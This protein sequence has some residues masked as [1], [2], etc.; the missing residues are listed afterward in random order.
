MSNQDT[1]LTMIDEDDE[2]RL[3]DLPDECLKSIIS[4]CDTNSICALDCTTR[5]LERLTDEIFAAKALHR[6][7]LKTTK[8]ESG[9]TKWRQGLALVQ[10]KKMFNIALTQ[11]PEYVCEVNREELAYTHI[12]THPTSS[13]ILYLG[14]NFSGGHFEILAGGNPVYCRDAQTLA[15]NAPKAQP[16][17]VWHVAACGPPGCE[18]MV[19]THQTEMIAYLGKRQQEIRLADFCSDVQVDFQRP[20]GVGIQLLGDEYFLIAVYHNA[21]FV[22][23][24]TPMHDKLLSFVSCTTFDRDDSIYSYNL[25]RACPEV[26][27]VFGFVPSVRK[28]SVWQVEPANSDAQPG[29]GESN[30]QCLQLDLI[31]TSETYQ[32]VA[33]GERY[34]AG[35]TTKDYNDDINRDFIRVYDRTS[36]EPIHTL[37]EPD[38]PEESGDDTYSGAHIEFVGHLL[39]ATSWLRGMLCVWNAATGTLLRRYNGRSDELIASPTWNN[40][41]DRYTQVRCMSRLYQAGSL[42]FLAADGP[43]LRLWSF[44]FNW[45]GETYSANLSN[46]EARL[47]T[48][49]NAFDFDR[50]PAEVGHHR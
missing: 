46:R 1:S 38:L 17:I 36:R 39:I 31:D 12:A 6:F 13:Q 45:R 16:W 8:N 9:K 19:T 35:S 10:P 37:Q 4:F 25:R 15:V 14:D 5:G 49:R 41:I 21:V 28:V 30:P 27:G 24:P 34:I 26:P 7:G 20:N 42:S 40:E 48:L 22:F 32:E 11:P 2:L 18:I 29:R 50:D 23:E 33:I 47:S 43:D 3:L 44:P